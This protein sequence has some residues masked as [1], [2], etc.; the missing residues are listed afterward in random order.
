MLR[1]ASSAQSQGSHHAAFCFSLLHVHSLSGCVCA[2]THLQGWL[3]WQFILVA[4]VI[5]AIVPSCARSSRQLW[6]VVRVCMLAVSLALM[7][8]FHRGQFI[9]A[10]FRPSSF[11]QSLP[12][13][14]LRLAMCSLRHSLALPLFG[15][16]AALPP[17][18]LPVSCSGPLRHS[19]AAPRRFSFSPVPALSLW[20]VSVSLRVCR[21][22][23][24]AISPLPFLPRLVSGCRAHSWALPAGSGHRLSC[25][26]AFSRSKITQRKVAIMFQCSASFQYR[27]REAGPIITRA[28]L[29]RGQFNTT[30]T[31]SFIGF[32]RSIA[33]KNIEV[34][35]R[36]TNPNCDH[37]SFWVSLEELEVEGTAN[38]EYCESQANPV[39]GK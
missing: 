16:L 36:C 38:C 27:I 20:L 14:R 12:P 31:G 35:L 25:H 26:S 29:T 32:L 23:P 28:N 9:S 6:P 39:T 21:C 11:S 22:S 17:P 18:C 30:T 24:S 34:A 10:L 4:L 13:G 7:L 8:K 15:R 5:S 1:T 33:H 19:R 2:R 37:R 3:A